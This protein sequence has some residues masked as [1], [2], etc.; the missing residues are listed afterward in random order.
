MRHIV[1]VEGCELE[2]LGLKVLLKQ[3]G[4]QLTITEAES[5]THARQALREN[6]DIDAVILDFALPDEDAG[7][8]Y[9]TLQ[10]AFPAP[11]YILKSDQ[12]DGIDAGVAEA[13]GAAAHIHRTAA[14]EDICESLR[15]VVNAAG[16]AVNDPNRILESLSPAQ[17]RI[18]KGL[19]KGLRNKQIAYEMGVTENTVRTYLSGMYR[20]LGVH[21]R[22]QALCL[23]RDVLV[24]TT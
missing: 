15:G 13:L 1:L 2:R 22:T 23:L 14:V 20:R 10:K 21:S 5:F 11:A 4:S 18:L 7:P 12:A 24:A 6:D 17:I 8:A 19:Q 16:P 3:L 9:F